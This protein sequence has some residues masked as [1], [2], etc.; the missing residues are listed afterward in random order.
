MAAKSQFFPDRDD[1]LNAWLANFVTVAASNEGPLG[2]TPADLT[3]LTNSQTGFST[4][5]ATHV[6]NYSVAKSSTQAKDAQRAATKKLFAETVAKIQLRPTVNDTLRSLL[7]ITIRKKPTRQEPKRP[8]NLGGKV[9]PS[10][11]S[12]KL[13]WSPAGNTYPTIYHVEQRIGATG[14]WTQV[15]VCT[16]CRVLVDLPTAGQ[17]FYRV[18]AQRNGA[19][20]EPS[21]ALVITE[22][23]ITLAVAA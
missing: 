22:G 4:A 23:A 16:A 13:K 7:G 1:E 6:Y 11:L 20:S 8:E 3:D 14:E 10:G 5:L 9:N 12:A 2:L 18:I 21:F 19:T 15:A 17:I